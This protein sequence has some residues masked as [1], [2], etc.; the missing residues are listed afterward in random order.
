MF[1]SEKL[2]KS[3]CH[4]QPVGHLRPSF[5]DSA[6][7]APSVI[8]YLHPCRLPQGYE[9]IRLSGGSIFISGCLE[10]SHGYRYSHARARLAHHQNETP[11]SLG[12]KVQARTGW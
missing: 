2:P 7:I 3:A 12:R 1:N 6:V 5:Q 10:H 4:A 8:A 9:A 11:R